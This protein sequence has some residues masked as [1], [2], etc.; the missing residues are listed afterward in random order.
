MLSLARIG[1][2]RNLCHLYEAILSMNRG[3][4]EAVRVAL[5]WR[6]LDGFLGPNP[7]GGRDPVVAGG[8]SGSHF[9]GTTALG[10]KQR[11]LA[12]RHSAS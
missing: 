7:A 1:A 3:V 6:R 11:F 2:I 8:R 10:Y 9:S 5:S 4:D 12:E